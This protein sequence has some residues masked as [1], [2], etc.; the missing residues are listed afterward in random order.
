MKDN[1]LVA[2]E[3][4]VKHF[5][6]R[7]N[8]IQMLFTREKKKVHAVNGVSF[9]IEEGQT[10]G[11]VG[12][13]GSG[14][15]T[16]G[17]LVLKLIEP[18]HGRIKFMGKDIT[19][20][21]P[22]E[23]RPLRRE[24][25]IVFQDPLAS[26]NPYMKI[27]EA[28]RHP[29]VIH[30]IGKNRVQQKEMVLEMLEKVNL[31]PPEEFYNRYPRQ[32][33]GGQRQRVVIARALIT[34]PKFVVADEAV[35]MLDVSIR[36]QL[37]KLMVDLKKEF[38][39]TY[40]FITHDLATTKYICDRIAVMYLGHIVEEG[41]F[42]DIYSEPAHPYTKALISA[43]PEPDPKIMKTKKKMIPSGEVPNAVEPPSG[44]PFH[45]RCP[46]KKDVCSRIFPEVVEISEGHKVACHIYAKK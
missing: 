37:L 44:C 5:P 3:N 9:R 12:E 41:S 32:I 42:K 20:L 27:G 36:S 7:M 26:L 10:L 23:M 46:Y 13:S 18:T 11:L 21:K 33:S 17:R 19:P 15:T 30:R 25:Q 40:L 2:V 38:N 43:V 31:Q 45:P 1:T 39:L 29:L 8:F 24:M 6:V 34:R 28:V 16:T 22:K 35:A 14:K 4:L